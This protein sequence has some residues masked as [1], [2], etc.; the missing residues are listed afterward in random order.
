LTNSVQVT[1]KLEFNRPSVGAPISTFT[2][3][4]LYVF[5]FDCG[6][7]VS[8]WNPYT[9]AY[10]AQNGPLTVFA[11]DYLDESLVQVVNGGSYDFPAPPAIFNLGD[12]PNGYVSTTSNVWPGT[13]WSGR[14][15]NAIVNNPNN[16]FLY[17]SWQTN[18]LDSPV[19]YEFSP[20]AFQPIVPPNSGTFPNPPAN[21]QW[22]QLPQMYL[23]VTNYLQAY[24]LDGSNVIDYVQLC[25]PNMVGN[26]TTAL[27]DPNYPS[28]PSEYYQWS[29]NS[30]P[31]SNPN[32][33][34]TFGQ[35]NQFF[36]SRNPADAPPGAGQWTDPAAFL[37]ASMIGAANTYGVPQAEAAYFT[38]FFTPIPSGGFTFDGQIFYNT[39]TTIQAPYTPIRTIVAPY[40]LQANDPLVHYLASNLNGQPGAEANWGNA[41][42]WPN[43]SWQHVDDSQDSSLPLPP[44]TPIGGRY[45]PWG[46]ATTTPV[47]GGDT[48]GYRLDYRDP[49]AWQSD[50]WNF[51]TNLMS[52][53]A[54][55]GQVHRGTPWQTVYL[56]ANNVL[57][58][59]YFVGVSPVN[60]GTNQW[61]VW[62]G[63]LNLNYSGNYQDASLMGPVSDW[64][65]AGLLMS[66]L[67]TNNPMQLFSVDD[68]NAADWQNILN[69]FV[70]YSNST[71]SLSLY[72][73]M[74]VQFDTY[75]MAG[76]SPQASI[77]ASSVVPNQPNQEYQS[78]GDI[79]AVPSLSVNSPWLNATNQYQAAYGINDVEYEAIPSQLLPLLRQDSI[80][81]L[82]PV[83]GGWNVQ[84][85]G[86]DGYCYAVQTS[87]DL[88]HWTTISTNQPVQGTFTVPVAS[89]NSSTGQYFRTVLLP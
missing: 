3:N 40:L 24:I 2:S 50:N 44:A 53:L 45:Q 76:N 7:G 78:I 79:L 11:R 88:V 8:F 4:E 28:S 66:L 30:Y 10:T 33:S 63:D 27:A 68:A 17:N 46:V 36:V 52:N 82:T 35:Y 37:P 65:L 49:L 70:V 54:G 6:V 5:S 75:V 57:T 62:T 21:P 69:G 22:P 77:I 34:P 14:A 81:A 41:S 85:S 56:K 39:Q 25:G 86:A 83:N 48:T 29:T 60:S 89:T 15:P 64:R 87:T 19:E 9:N 80:G 51:P 12:N 20:P 84:F 23:A 73:S 26:L 43:G 59:S 16:C 38:A 1:R 72:P 58:N 32:S 67:N 61:A 13:Q 47:T 18:F 55:L 71:P 42:I 31:T 74:P